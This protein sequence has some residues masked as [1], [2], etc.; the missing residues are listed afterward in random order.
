M[1]FPVRPP[2]R[3]LTLVEVMFSIVIMST[4][5]VAALGTV[6]AA[7]KSRLAQRD[8][9]MGLAL[10]RQL[11]GEIMQTRYA[12]LV[13]ATFG[14]EAGETRATFDDV[15]DYNNL[16]E[17]SA[18]YADGTV[19]AG[20][21]GWQRRATVQW[22][23]PVDPATVS[24]TDQGL[25]R[26]TVTVTSPG[27]KVTTLVSLRSNG[28]GYENTPGSQA[29]YTCWAG[30]SLQVGSYANARNTQGTNL[31]NLIP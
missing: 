26:I 22:V 21:T 9:A 11:T 31:L 3:G 8:S 17:S 14:I 28:D 29:T 13:D 23:T 12:D 18:A 19:I 15:D 30:V 20:A 25:K 4:M 6:G 10:A 24:A 27:G 1:T 2:R 7:A 5:M 16:T